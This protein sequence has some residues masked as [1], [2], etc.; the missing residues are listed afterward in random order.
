[1][2]RIQGKAAGLTP[3]STLAATAEVE[4]AELRQL[5]EPLWTQARVSG[6]VAASLRAAGTLAKP[7]L[8]GTVRGDALGFDMPPWGIALRDGSLRAELEGD[9]LRVL[10]ARI[11]GGDG[12]LTASGILGKGASTLDWQATQFRVLGRPDRR[13]IASGKGTA[14]FDGKKLGLAGE[15]RADGGH[16]ELA[17]DSLQQLDESVEI[18]GAERVAAAKRAP[19][20]INLDLELDLGS[21]LTLRGYGYHGGVGGLVRVTTTGAR[22]RPRARDPRRDLP[23][24]RAGARGRPGPGHLRRPARRARPRHQRVAPPPAGRS[25]HQAHRHAAGAAR[26]VDLESAGERGGEAFVAGA[27]ARADRGARGGSRGAA[28]GERRDPRSRRR[29]GAARQALRVALRPGRD[30]P[31]QLERARKQR[32]GARQALRQA[33]LQLRTRDRDDDGIP[34]EAGLLAHAAHLVARPDRHHERR[35]LFLPLLVGLV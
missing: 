19:L 28:G 7:V 2:A 24:L 30:R 27:R 6:R 26:R 21:R 10:E 5:T 33:L 15:L 12:S 8:G 1:S 31:A 11:A 23:R 22:A 25:R 20:P 35:G 16:F 14:R 3:D 13:L 17:E 18:E 29:R 4:L 32:G 9:R 34:G